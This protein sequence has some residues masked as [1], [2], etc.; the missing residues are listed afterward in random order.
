MVF[1]RYSDPDPNLELFEYP[2]AHAKCRGISI[3]EMRIC[4]AKFFKFDDKI[5]QDTLLSDLMQVTKPKRKRGKIEG[6]KHNMAVKYTLLTTSGHS[7]VCQKLFLAAFNVSQKRV[8][9]ICKKMKNG[10]GIIEKRGGIGVW[11]NCFNIN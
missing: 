11:Q 6:R 5:K 3:P 10:L 9:N 7:N 4:R 8:E 2:C 1:V